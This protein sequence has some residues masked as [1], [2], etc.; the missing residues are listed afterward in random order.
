[1][2]DPSD[3][4]LATQRLSKRYGRSTWALRDV[5]LTIMQGETVALVGPNG[6][7]KSTLLRTWVGFERP[8]AGRAVTSG[9]DSIRSR[10]QAVARVAYVGQDAP[11]LARLSAIEHFRLASALRRSF[12]SPWALARLEAMGIPHARP[13][14]RLSGGQR[15]QVALS[16]ALATRAPTI[17]LDEP[18]A[19]LDPLARRQFMTEAVSFARSNGSTLVLA[20]HVVSDI[21]PNSGRLVL[22]NAGRVWADMPIADARRM[23]HVSPAETTN[24]SADVVGVF[25]DHS[26]R[27]LA[28]MRGRASSGEYADLEDVVLGFLSASSTG[29][30]V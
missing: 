7:G 5:D 19:S 30:A 8:S 14:N 18:L 12:D 10:T 28:L 9:V 21:D 4:A 11:L 13:V 15:A 3:V 1:M 23:H 20:S 6:A 26:G 2:S 22:L 25:R 27:E 29:R 16:I 24:G 17:L